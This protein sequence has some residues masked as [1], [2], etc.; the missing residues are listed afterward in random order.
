MTRWVSEDF[1]KKMC[2][3]A[4]PGVSFAC[5]SQEAFKKWLYIYNNY[6][7][8]LLYVPLLSKPLL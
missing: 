3:G 8:Y 7:S 1:F 4:Q 5:L 2:V 6:I